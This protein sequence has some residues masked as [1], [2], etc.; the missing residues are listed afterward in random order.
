MAINRIQFQPGLS[1]PE[2]LAR[3]G[4]EKQCALS[5]CKILFRVLS[6]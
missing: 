3:H 2:F 5:V 6:S 4:T 1:L